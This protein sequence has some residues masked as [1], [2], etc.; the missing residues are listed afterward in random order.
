MR[1]A[2]TATDCYREIKN[3]G[4][5]CLVTSSIGRRKKIEIV[6]Y[7]DRNNRLGLDL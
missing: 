1:M 3:G 4:R 7:P 6:K 5:P 2:K